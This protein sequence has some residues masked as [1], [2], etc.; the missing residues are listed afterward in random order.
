LAKK[1]KKCPFCA[2]E[3]NKENFDRHL[4]KVHSDLDEKDF[5]KKGLKAPIGAASTKKTQKE[6]KKGSRKRKPKKKDR[7][8]TV[9][10]LV[11][12]IIIVS[13]I[14]VVIYNNLSQNGGQGGDSSN[15]GNGGG[16]PIAVMT[17]SL[18]VI[19]IELDTEKAPNTAQN[20]MDL[21]N[22]GF[23]N[24]IIFIG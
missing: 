18:G 24:G 15:N 16:K 7:T 17:T 6:G 12:L 1:R 5:K 20:F 14:G 8:S 13:L 3:V 9:V 23:F 19:K 10:S 11:A 4:L 2:A 22:S 21:A